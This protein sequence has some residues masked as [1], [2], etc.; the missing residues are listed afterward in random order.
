[1]AD[2]ESLQDLLI[3][4]DAD[5][6]QYLLNQLS[7]KKM[8]VFLTSNQLAHPQ[9]EKF[10]Q[11]EYQVSPIEEMYT[12][13]WGVVHPSA[14]VRSAL[15]N[16]FVPKQLDIVGV[17]QELPRVEKENSRMRL[18]IQTDHTFHKPQADIRLEIQ[19]PRENTASYFAQMELYQLLLGK[20]NMKWMQ[21]A[22]R[23]GYTGSFMTTGKG[24]VLGF[25]G[26]TDKLEVFAQ[27]YMGRLKSLDLS[28]IEFKNIKDELITKIENRKFSKAYELGLESVELIRDPTRFSPA[29]LVPTL[30]SLTL[31]DMKQFAQNLVPQAFVVGY[32]FGNV[33]L[34]LVE[35]VAEEV[36]SQFHSQEI[37][38][39]QRPFF[40]TVKFPKGQAFNH[41]IYLSGENHAWVLNY[42]FGKS[43]P[44]L[45]AALSVGESV[46]ETQFFDEMRTQRTLG[47]IVSARAAKGLLASGMRFIIQSDHSLDEVSG[48]AEAWIQE[49]AQK[50][51]EIS[52]EEFLQIKAAILE[53]WEP[54][55]RSF[56][57]KYIHFMQGIFHYGADMNW[58]EKRMSALRQLT[59]S[60]VVEVFRSAFDQAKQRKLTIF[61]IGDNGAKSSLNR[62][63]EIEIKDIDLFKQSTD[64]YRSKW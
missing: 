57:S 3:R 44:K 6:F 49:A 48:I 50:I 12:A 43:T 22:S 13:F 64:R 5:A 41:Q 33:T 58:K 2:I 32:G 4:Y 9:N 36:F 63:G 45:E 7:P 18:W 51:E 61:A 35:R 40:E 30:K 26:Y 59:Q 47:Y 23:A 53:E 20:S 31:Q 24:I 19:T 46:L 11:I 16:P 10:Y 62:P 27:E 29:R 55:F 54:D 21:P 39:G 15:P 25:S 14:A 42:Q 52:D 38:E 60:E 37:P 8:Q 17:H 56:E 1:V 28:E 34:Q